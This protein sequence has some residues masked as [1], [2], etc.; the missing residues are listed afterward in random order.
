MKKFE[1]KKIIQEVL[2]E[3]IKNNLTEFNE[4]DDYDTEAAKKEMENLSNL[5]GA[6][7]THDD[8]FPNDEASFHKNEGWN[9]EAFEEAGIMNVL[10]E[11][12]RAIYE[13]KNARRGAYADLGEDQEEFIE[14]LG[15]LGQQLFEVCAEALN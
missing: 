14:G 3:E 15:E 5:D 6:E 9:E 11:I 10:S 13:I 8:V 4:Y 12:E 2:K 7:Y 1:L